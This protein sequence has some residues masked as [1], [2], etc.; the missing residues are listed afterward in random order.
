V[1]VFVGAGLAGSTPASRLSGLGRAPVVVECS[2]EPGA[3]RALACRYP[4][5]RALARIIESSRAPF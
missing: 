2:T 3:C 4:A 1:R 5:T